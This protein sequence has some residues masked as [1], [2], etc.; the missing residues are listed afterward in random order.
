MRWVNVLAGVVLLILAAAPAR[1]QYGAPPADGSGT[2]C[3]SNEERETNDDR[4]TPFDPDYLIGR[5]ETEWDVPDTPLG[6]GGRRTGI[7]T[8]RYIEG[9]YYEG[10][11]VGDGPDGAF[12]V[13][14]RIIFDP[15]RQYMV[16][17]EDDS[18][19]QT[20][21]RTGQV[22]GEPGGYFM[23]YWQTP[24]TKINGSDVRLRGT[25]FFSSPVNY[26]LR[27]RISIDGGPY[28][29]F[30]NPWFSKQDETTP[31]SQRAR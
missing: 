22:A 14:M 24:V 8:F 31:T 5:W 2:Q 11:F 21:V 9:C 26:R 13:R 15:A 25:T 18:R 3:L 7:A 20:L 12:D 19:G 27:A 23:H 10:E 1:A 28:L 17:I 4:Q 30:G 16:W 29:N 6:Q